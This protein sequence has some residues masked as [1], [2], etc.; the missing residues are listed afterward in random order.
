LPA[1]KIPLGDIRCWPHGA[2]LRFKLDADVQ[3][4]YLYVR[5]TDVVIFGGPFLKSPSDGNTTW[6]IRQKVLSYAFCGYG[7]ARPDQLEPRP[8]LPITPSVGTFAERP[9]KVKNPREQEMV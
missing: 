5:G 2:R 9:A 7:W 4:K 3:R 6:C 1:V 8:G